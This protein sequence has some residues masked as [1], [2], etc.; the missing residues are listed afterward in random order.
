MDKEIDFIIG[1]QEAQEKFKKENSEFI[2]FF[3]DLV[4]AFNQAFH[5]KKKQRKSILLMG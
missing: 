1:D 5:R 4:S 2:E 3:P